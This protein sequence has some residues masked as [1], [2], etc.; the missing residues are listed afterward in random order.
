MSI[1]NDQPLQHIIATTNAAAITA[2]NTYH[3]IA[4]CVYDAYAKYAMMQTI[5]DRISTCKSV[6]I[7]LRNPNCFV[8][9]VTIER[10]VHNIATPKRINDA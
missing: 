8:N 5:I 1:T 6:G 10:N 3:V 2:T 7:L 9:S 4:T